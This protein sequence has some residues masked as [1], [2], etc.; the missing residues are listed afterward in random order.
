MT[1]R[2]EVNPAGKRLGRETVYINGRVAKDSLDSH[3]TSNRGGRKGQCSHLWRAENNRK[4]GS[5]LPPHG[6]WVPGL[7]GC[8]FPLSYLASTH[9]KRKKDQCCSPRR[10]QNIGKSVWKRRIDQVR[11]PW[12][13]TGIAW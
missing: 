4:V 5:L 3:S 2:T 10:N 13:L 8:A 11:D 12:M 7:G 9:L 1:S 6:T